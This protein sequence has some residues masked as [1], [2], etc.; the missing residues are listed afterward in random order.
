MSSTTTAYILVGVLISGIV[1]LVWLL[2]RKKSV[3]T[4]KAPVTIKMDKALQVE[5]KTLEDRAV[6]VAISEAAVKQLDEIKQIDDKMERLSRMAKLLEA[7]KN[8]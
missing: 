4:I 3:T 2:L 7:S 1:G 6:T 8:I 5:L